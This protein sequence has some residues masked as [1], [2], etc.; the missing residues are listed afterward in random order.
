MSTM[1]VTEEYENAKYEVVHMYARKKGGEKF[2]DRI[3]AVYLREDAKEIR[4]EHGFPKKEL[5]EMDGQECFVLSEA[6]PTR[7]N[8]NRVPIYPYKMA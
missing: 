5:L 1:N 8:E 6:T 2:T 7:F 4:R 3:V